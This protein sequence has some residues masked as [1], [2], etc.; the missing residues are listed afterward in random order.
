MKKCSNCNILVK[1]EAKYCEKCGKKVDSENNDNQSESISVDLVVPILLSIIFPIIIKN[2]AEKLEPDKLFGNLPKAQRLFNIPMVLIGIWF[3]YFIWLLIKKELKK[4]ER[5]NFILAMYI[6]AFIIFS[7]IT[8]VF[9]LTG[10]PIEVFYKA[11]YF[12]LGMFI[13]A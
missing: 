7:G 10:D 2:D 3:S 5:K 6:I 11:V 1:D 12:I 9:L 13:G 8:L 4:E